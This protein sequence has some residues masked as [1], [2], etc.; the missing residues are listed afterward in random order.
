MN[1]IRMATSNNGKTSYNSFTNSYIRFS[2][3][4]SSKNA[5][6]RPY[7]FIMPI[8]NESSQQS[9][10][11]PFWDGKPSPIV[12]LLSRWPHYPAFQWKENHTYYV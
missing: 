6:S 9:F 10:R 5:M 4:R 7:R 11:G 8:T 2:D 12:L 3:F 1:K